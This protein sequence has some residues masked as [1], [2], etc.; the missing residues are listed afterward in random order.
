MPQPQLG[1]KAQSVQG[2]GA[3]G[4]GRF[5]SLGAGRQ[6]EEEDDS[7]D[8]EESPRG[9]RVVRETRILSQVHTVR[10][11][12]HQDQ[13]RVLKRLVEGWM[14]GGAAEY[15]V[16]QQR[17]NELHEEQVEDVIDLWAKVARLEEVVR[18]LEASSSESESAA[19]QGGLKRLA[20]IRGP[21]D[22]RDD[23]RPPSAL[24]VGS[25]AELSA[26]AGRETPDE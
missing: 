17:W 18:E 3:A 10:R 7:G 1:S 11:P 14:S 21:R 19:P 26:R 2:A 5:A 6:H 20:P 23:S 24:S 25:K 16:Q 9:P 13:M 12:V 4:P 22:G 15:R 8:E